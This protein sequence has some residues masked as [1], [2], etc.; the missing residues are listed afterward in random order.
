MTI[1]QKQWQLWYLGYYGGRIDGIWGSKSKAATK[2]FQE[3]NGLKPDGDFGPL[4][5]GKSKEIIQGIQEVVGAAVDGLAGTQTKE[6]TAVWQAAY[7]LAADGIA[8]PLTRAA[9]EEDAKDFWAGIKYFTREDFACTCGGKYCNGYPVKMQR[10]IVEV[11]DRVRAHFGAAAMVSSG[12]RCEKHNA[13]VGGVP[14]SRH[15]LGKAVDFCVKGRSAAQ[16]LA[17]VKQQPE[18]RYCY[19]IDNNYVHMDIL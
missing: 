3:E 12:L 4:T 7:G 5:A 13:S 9:L 10:K 19:A 1:K 6:A 16:V 18:I 14:G 15:K 2:K 8:G 11:A 17:Y